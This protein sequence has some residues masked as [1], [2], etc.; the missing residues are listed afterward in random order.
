MQEEL[1]KE[2]MEYMGKMGTE[3]SKENIPIVDN[4][5]HEF[6]LE[7]HD[8]EDKSEVEEEEQES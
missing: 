1:Q 2:I 5:I 6:P 3:M 7:K 8:E 4:I